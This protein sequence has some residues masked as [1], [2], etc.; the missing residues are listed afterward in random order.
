MPQP[1][2]SLGDLRATEDRAGVPWGLIELPEPNLATYSPTSIETRRDLTSALDFVADDSVDLTKRAVTA[3]PVIGVLV[4]TQSS[5]ATMA[6]EDLH[7]AAKSA[8]RS[9]VIV[10][11]E[12]S[13]CMELHELR[14][15]TG[16]GAALLRVD[17]V[18]T[19]IVFEHDLDAVLSFR[20][21]PLRN[22]LC[23]WQDYEDLRAMLH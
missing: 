3:S 23:R 13:H 12:F 7:V 6:N 9:L 18:L 4:P 14:P 8:G 11:V 17:G 16:T 19:G 20:I 22:P 1:D 15:G 2:A 10:P 5:G 21:G